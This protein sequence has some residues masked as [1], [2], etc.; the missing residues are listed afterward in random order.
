MNVFGTKLIGVSKLKKVLHYNIGSV[1]ETINSGKLIKIL[2]YLNNNFSHALY[3]KYEK[4]GLNRNAVYDRTGAIPHFIN[5]SPIHPMP[6]YDPTFNKSFYQVA[7]E[8]AKELLAIGKPIRVCWSGGIDSTFTL[9]FLSKF[10][11]DKSQVQLYGTFASIIESGDAWDKHI[12][13]K[14]TF[15]I[16]VFPSTKI[17]TIDDDFIYVSG[18]Q[19]NQL[20]G[21]TDNFF[22]SNRDVAF[23]HHTLGTKETIYEDY[24]KYI[25][26]ELL[27]FLQ[28]SIDLSPRKIETIC[29][30]RWYCIF[31]MD[32]YNGLYT[33][34]GEMN[35]KAISRTHH[36]FDSIEFQKWAIHT[37]DPF[38]KVRG[39]ANTHRWQ[40]REFLADCGLKDYAKTKSK[41]ISNFSSLSG[42]WAFLTE[43]YENIYV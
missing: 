20:F 1:C 14:F 37:N 9:Y 4:F 35:R 19:G 31:N 3:K 23:F 8:R 22:A 43:N 33:M 5:M 28:P 15:E 6:D 12:K 42:N 25:A 36:F 13:N 10:A 11:N 34:R 38:T 29:D 27:E 26:P 32:W 40:M 24:K 41:A 7:E 2:P 21:P 17:K 18:F 30:L 16:N 39:D